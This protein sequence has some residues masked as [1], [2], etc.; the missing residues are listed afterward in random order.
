MKRG[1]VIVAS[2]A[3][4]ALAL[5]KMLFPDVGGGARGKLQAALERD[6]DYVA[7]FR[8]LGK[9]LSL[10]PR[11]EKKEPENDAVP[12]DA[13]ELRL[14]S[15]YVEDA[16]TSGETEPQAPEE[17]PVPAA[18]TAF[19]ERQAA[20]SDY[21]LPENVDYGYSALPFDYALPVAGRQSSGFGYRLHPILNV[22]RFHFGTDVA[23]GAGETITA[24]ADGTVVFAGYDESYGWHLKIDHGDGWVSHYCHCSRLLVQTEQAVS[25][26][27]A[28]ALVGATGLATGPHLHF[29]LTKDGV[30]LN[31]EYYINAA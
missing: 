11:D 5:M 30:F 2:T 20:F 19:L 4:A 15:Y 27:D 8:E 12:A 18:V 31:P 9:K 22:V 10:N 14:V 25:M 23:A 28:V 21:T 13:P 16:A 29:E 6:P 7:A 26:G 3:F 24:F 17:T 1:S